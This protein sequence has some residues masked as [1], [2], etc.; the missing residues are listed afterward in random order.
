[1]WRAIGLA[2]KTREFLRKCGYLSVATLE[3]TQLII[4]PGFVDSLVGWQQTDVSDS[5]KLTLH[6]EVTVEQILDGNK[7]IILSITGEQLSPLNCFIS[8][9]K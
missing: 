5:L 2:S 9:P 3:A 7:S 6:P 8:E 4:G 1:M